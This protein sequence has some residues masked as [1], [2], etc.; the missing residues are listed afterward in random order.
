MPGALDLLKF[1]SGGAYYDTFHQLQ[2][3]RGIITKYATI[4]ETLADPYKG[5]SLH[6]GLT[7]SKSHLLSPRTP[8]EIL[9]ILGGPTNI[10]NG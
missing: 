7:H 10:W 9:Q 8:R 6:L 3:I 1:E 5:K 4:T 2:K